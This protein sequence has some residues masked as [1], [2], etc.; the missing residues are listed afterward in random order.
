VACVEDRLKKKQKSFC[1]AINPEKVYRAARDR[2]LNRILAQADMGICDGVGIS[3]AA[4]L[5]Y[6]ERIR[7]CTGV[8]LFYALI[9][10]AVERQWKIFLLGASPAVNAKASDALYAKYPGLQIAGRHD[11]YF[12]N[13]AAVVEQIN[14][15]GA[16]LVFVAM[17]TPRQEF[18]I[19][20]NSSKI[21]AGFLMGVGGTFDVV[22]GLVR[23]APGIFR[24]TGTEF[25][26][27]LIS[28]PRRWRRQ[29]VLPSFFV[30]VL[31]HRYRLRR[32]RMGR[33]NKIAYDKQM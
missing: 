2:E 13:S 30:S 20:E 26:Y 28:N 8:D 32:R 14:A 33:K 22:S 29:L 10:K 11:G 21:N 31:I 1:V 17:G 16:D 7:R 4:R 15:S 6:G 12:E 25:L 19:A 27:R 3:I 5:I 23:R 24:R 18:W 9:A